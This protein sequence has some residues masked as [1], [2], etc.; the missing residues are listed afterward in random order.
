[1]KLIK[2]GHF[3]LAGALSACAT[4]STYEMS[5]KAAA[6]LAE[7]KHTGEVVRCLS[8]SAISEI[9]PLDAQNFLIRVGVNR[10]Y[11]NTVKGTCYGADRRSNRLQYSISINQLC[12]YEVIGVVDNTSGLTVGSCVLGDFERLETV[13][14]D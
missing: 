13:E 8:R 3:I 4:A 6:Q 9:R 10:Y 2:L 12:K 5:E 7:F 14:S 1:M 11:L